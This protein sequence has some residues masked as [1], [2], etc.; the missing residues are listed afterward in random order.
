MIERLGKLH[1]LIELDCGYIIKRHIDQLIKSQVDRITPQINL[2]LNIPTPQTQRHLENKA[3]SPIKYR[4]RVIEPS[5]STS[6]PETNGNEDQPQINDIPPPVESTSPKPLRRSER[7]RKP[8][9]R[10]NYDS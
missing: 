4:T 5:S 2:H 7:T 9:I 8:V 10:L 3:T 1:Y 6:S